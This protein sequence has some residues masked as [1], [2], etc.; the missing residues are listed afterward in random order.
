MAGKRSHLKAHIG[1][2]I[3]LQEIELFKQVETKRRLLMLLCSI[4]VAQ[5][6]EVNNAFVGESCQDSILRK[7]FYYNVLATSL[8]RQHIMIKW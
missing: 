7:A 4:N 1:P 8:R 3:K 5:S 2:I 6:V